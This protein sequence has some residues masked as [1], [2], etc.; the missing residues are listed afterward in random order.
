MKKLIVALCLILS[1]AAGAAIPSI[2]AVGMYR[3]MLSTPDPEGNITGGCMTCAWPRRARP[4]CVSVQSVAGFR[5]EGWYE[6]ASPGY[7]WPL[8]TSPLETY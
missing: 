3:A 5:A 4:R 6:Q 1:F 2:V 8:L 7:E